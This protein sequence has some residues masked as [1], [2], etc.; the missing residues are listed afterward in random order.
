[1]VYFEMPSSFAI[2]ATKILL[3]IKNSSKLE[4]LSVKEFLFKTIQRPV[5]REHR[6]QIFQK[7]VLL[8]S[9]LPMIFQY[10][11]TIDGSLHQ[12]RL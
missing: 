7:V 9:I 3:L 4:S 1:M 12:V 5:D 6:F 11:T 2:A 10:E 8:F